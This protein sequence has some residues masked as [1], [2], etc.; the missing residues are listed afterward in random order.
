M[1]AIIEALNVAY[2]V[3]VISRL[4]VTREERKALRRELSELRSTA[5][6][7]HSGKRFFY[8]SANP[9]PYAPG[10]AYTSRNPVSLDSLWI[11]SHERR[12]SA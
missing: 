7:L 4:Y 12:A 8:R 6:T 10:K 2:D 3:R 1:G 11:R 9:L 5:A